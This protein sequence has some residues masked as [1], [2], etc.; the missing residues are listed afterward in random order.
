[1]RLQDQEQHC[2][3]HRLRDVSADQRPDAQAEGR[4]PDAQHSVAENI[5]RQRGGRELPET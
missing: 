2:P 4:E 5:G 3:D 1:M